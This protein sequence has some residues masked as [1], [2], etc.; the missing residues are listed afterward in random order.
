VAGVDHV[1]T[2]AIIGASDGN[3]LCLTDN[4]LPYLET[5]TIAL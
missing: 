4:E 5:I 2:I 3:A 1:N